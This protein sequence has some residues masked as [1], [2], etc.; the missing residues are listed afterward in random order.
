MKGYFPHPEATAAAFTEDGWLRTG[1]K[2][3]MDESAGFSS[4]TA[5][6]T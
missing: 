6:P 2:G 5:R 4:W 1:D 3:C